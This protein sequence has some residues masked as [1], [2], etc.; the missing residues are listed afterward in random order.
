MDRADVTSALETTASDHVQKL[1]GRLQ[2]AWKEVNDPEG[3]VDLEEFLPS[4]DD[5]LRPLA[6]QALVK[7]DLEIRWQ[8]GRG[9]QVE[10]YLETFP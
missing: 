8:P 1:V 7:A 5:S 3:S 10:S 4:Q 6:L 9:V 2:R